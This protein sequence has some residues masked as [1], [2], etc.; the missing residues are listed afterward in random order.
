MGKQT[1]VRYYGTHE[2]HPVDNYII[3]SITSLVNGLNLEFGGISADI[4]FY[5]DNNVYSVTLAWEGKVFIQLVYHPTRVDSFTKFAEYD[6]LN[7]MCFMWLA[8]VHVYR[9]LSQ[10]ISAERER[11]T[12]LFNKTLQQIDK[13]KKDIHKSEP[14]VF[15]ASCHLLIS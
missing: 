13:N 3:S 9:R 8:G 12:N 7:Q 6:D 5:D 2:K 15:E 14:S 4:R 11:M 10:V 1:S